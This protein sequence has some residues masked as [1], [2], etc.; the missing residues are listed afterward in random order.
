MAVEATTWALRVPVGGTAKV[1][2]LGVANH[3]HPDGSEAYPSIKRLAEYACCDDRTVTRALRKLESEG[4]ILRD[5]KGPRGQNKYRL[6]IWRRPTDGGGQN[7][8]DDIGGPGEAMD[9]TPTPDIHGAD[10]ALDV[11]PADCPPD[12]SVQEGVAPVSPEPSYEPS[13][14]SLRSAAAARAHSL[15]A[16]EVDDWLDEAFE[17]GRARRQRWASSLTTEGEQRARVRV[18]LANV[19][20]PEV[21]RAVMRDLADEITKPKG[22]HSTLADSARA[23]IN[24]AERRERKPVGP[25][26]SSLMASTVSKQEAA[27]LQSDREFEAALRAAQEARSNG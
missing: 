15:H 16:A 5:G 17:A 21:A 11:A 27:A 18:L 10:E 19:G 1:V 23:F 4:W 22:L 26:P 7:A 25:L 3:A 13:S 8:P 20:D 2:L 12:T 6:A 9:V 24:E 14:A